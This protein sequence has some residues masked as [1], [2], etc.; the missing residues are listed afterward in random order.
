MFQKKGVGTRRYF[1]RLRRSWR[2]RRQISLDYITTAPPPNLTRLLHNTASYAGYSKSDCKMWVASGD[3]TGCG[4]GGR[5]WVGLYEQRDHTGAR[6]IHGS[7]LNCL[8][9]SPLTCI[10]STD[11]TVEERLLDRCSLMNRAKYNI[12]TDIHAFIVVRLLDWR[13]SSWKK[14]GSNGVPPQTHAVLT[15]RFL[16]WEND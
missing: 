3:A 12:R 14:F 2:L 10:Y 1:S 13:A 8:L 5:H 4:L 7:R 6:T 9:C 16:A 15:E 11:F